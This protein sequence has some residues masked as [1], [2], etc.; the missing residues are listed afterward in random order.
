MNEVV[1]LMSYTH[2]GHL[3]FL[4]RSCTGTELF[5]RFEWYIWIETWI[6][7]CHT[8]RLYF[9]CADSCLF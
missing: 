5:D 1:I 2:E 8:C 9:A 3:S 7:S 4:Q 6:P